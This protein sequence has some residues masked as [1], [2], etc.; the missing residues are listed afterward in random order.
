M[1]VVGTK[2]YPQGQW[3][4]AWHWGQCPGPS[5]YE[6]RTSCKLTFDPHTCTMAHTHPPHIHKQISVSWNF[7]SYSD[8]ND[9]Q[10]S[11]FQNEKYSTY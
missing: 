1:S 11:S 6:E 8:T 9:N 4:W 3:D 10:R 5:W 2:K 7:I